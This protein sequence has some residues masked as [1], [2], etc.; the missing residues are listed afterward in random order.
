MVIVMVAQRIYDAHRHIGVMPA[1]PF[2]G[3]PPVHP[4]ISARATVAELI[5]DLD[6]EGTERAL[7]IPNY[8]VP[9]PTVSFSLNEL[10]LEAA[11]ADDR[12]SAGIWTSP[13]PQDAELNDKALA[14]AGEPGVKVLKTSFLLGGRA[15]DPE[16]KV[17]LDRIFDTARE[18]NL[19]VH[20]H[21]SPGGNSDIDYVGTLVDR[22][23]D[24]V[25]IHL[26]H[27]GGGV[28]AH[29]KLI[30]HRFFDWIE[31]GKQVYTDTSWAVG[32]APRWLVRE[33]DKRGI[34]QDRLLFASDE[35][36]GDQAGELARL[37]A[38]AGDG[39]LANLFL[40]DN[41]AALYG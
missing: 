26:V 19:V 16:C 9:D 40:R 2:Y 41:F 18:H 3:G 24:D 4:D 10:A 37:C 35:P 12:I 30:G 25:K 39:E 11:A 36:W 6:R 33:I 14:L 32:F 22:Y 15:D 8:G 5:A 1:Y 13:R 7:V 29:I 31:A 17:Q 20:V 23:A 21:T 27:L 38:A 34:G 28:S